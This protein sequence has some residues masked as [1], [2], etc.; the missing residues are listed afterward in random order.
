MSVQSKPKQKGG[1][2]LEILR[3]LLAVIAALAAVALLVLNVVSF[4][5]GINYYLAMGYPPED[6]YKH[7]IPSQLLPGIFEPLTIYGG[8]ALLLIYVGRI[9]R[10]ISDCQTSGDSDDAVEASLKETTA[11][12]DSVSEDSR[13]I[14]PQVTD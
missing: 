1:S 7:L 10:R 11:E 4:L 3:I 2:L 8:M 14:E 6:V 9:N 5:D 12:P 13:P